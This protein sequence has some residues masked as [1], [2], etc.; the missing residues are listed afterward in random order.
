MRLRAE[1]FQI[2]ENQKGGLR[3]AR[4]VSVNVPSDTSS[5]VTKSELTRMENLIEK[6]AADVSDLKA[7]M[8][9]QTLVQ[10]GVSGNCYPGRLES[11]GNHNWQSGCWVCGDKNHFKRDCPQRRVYNGTSRVITERVSSR[12]S[13]KCSLPDRYWFKRY[14][15]FY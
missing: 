13:Y 10:L 1:A 4:G 9:Q 7:Q 2:A 3:N 15:R 6:L 14:N 12:E 5:M 11:Y 8:Q